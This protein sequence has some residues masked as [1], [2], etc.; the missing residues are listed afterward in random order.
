M[1]S[2]EGVT[3][4]CAAVLADVDGIAHAFSTRRAGEGEFDLGPATATGEPWHA[5]RSRLARAAGMGDL[6]LL[7]P[8]QIHGARVVGFGDFADGVVPEADAVAAWRETSG[9]A[10]AART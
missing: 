9:A 6:P 3:V 10:A 5:R 8:R 7:A 2:R 4:V 1:V